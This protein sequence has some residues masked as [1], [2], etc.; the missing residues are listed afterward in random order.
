MVRG[1][2]KSPMGCEMLP[3]RGIACVET[4]TAACSRTRG[5]ARVPGRSWGLGAGVR[6]F[7]SSLCLLGTSS[8]SGTRDQKLY[9]DT[10]IKKDSVPCL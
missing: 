7:H 9:H 2:E 8:A 6:K 5:P 10:N 1:A 3:E 4:D